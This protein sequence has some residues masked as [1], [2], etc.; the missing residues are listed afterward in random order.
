[1]VS[2][3]TKFLL[4]K[5]GKFHIPLKKKSGTCH[6]YYFQFF[7]KISV[8]TIVLKTLPRVKRGIVNEKVKTC[9]NTLSRV[10]GLEQFQYAAHLRRVNC[11]NTHDYQ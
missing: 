9:Y 7:K 3:M 5:D 2:K 4:V 11:I 1:M 8:N 6:L 10:G